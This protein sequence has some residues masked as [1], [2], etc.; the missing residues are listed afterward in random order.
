MREN[1]LVRNKALLEMLNLKNATREIIRPAVV[2]RPQPRRANTSAAQLG[3]TRRSTRLAG[4]RSEGDD[5][6]GAEEEGERGGDGE[7]DAGGADVDSTE[8]GEGEGEEG[9]ERQE[10]G[11]KDDEESGNPEDE[12]DEEEGEREEGGEHQAGAQ[13]ERQK[14]GENVGGEQARWPKWLAD[15]H[16]LL[17]ACPEDG[18]EWKEVV[19]TWVQLEKAYGFKTSVSLPKF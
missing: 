19:E 8:G 1:A 2:E 10:V 5:E 4:Q 16:T 17:S 13:K 18:S 7:T 15:G 9:G 3:P 14:G 12:G 6:M 11:G